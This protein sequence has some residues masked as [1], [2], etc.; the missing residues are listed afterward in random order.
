MRSFYTFSICVRRVWRYHI[1]KRNAGPPPRIDSVQFRANEYFSACGGMYNLFCD[2]IGAIYLETTGDSGLDYDYT[3]GGIGNGLA[4]WL[5]FDTTNSFTP[6]ED[7][8]SYDKFYDVVDNPQNYPLWGSYFSQYDQIMNTTQNVDT[9][10]KSY[11]FSTSEIENMRKGY[12]VNNTGTHDVLIWH[13]PGETNSFHASYY[14][15]RFNS[16]VSRS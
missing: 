10:P 5:A 16:S 14:D 6:R 15:D 3:N 7:L 9:C 11:Q 12:T 8:P 13:I 2:V 1:W 4:F